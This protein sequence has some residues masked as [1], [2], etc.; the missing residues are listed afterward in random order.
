MLYLIG[1]GLNAKGI[2]VE[3]MEIAKRCKR[4]Y[5]ENYTVDFPY[6]FS[7]I[8]HVLGKDVEVLNRE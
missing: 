1:L 6:P 8:V 4:V 3:G 2:S 7:T 5:I